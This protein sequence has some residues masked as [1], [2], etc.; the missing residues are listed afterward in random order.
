M[1]R[2][3]R[4]ERS[5]RAPPRHI[6]P[7]VRVARLCRRA[8]CRRRA[9][10]TRRGRPAEPRRCHGGTPATQAWRF[11]CSRVHGPDRR[12]EDNAVDARRG[13]ER[14]NCADRIGRRHAD[15]PSARVSAAVVEL[16]PVP[17]MRLLDAALG[18]TDLARRTRRQS[19]LN[20]E[21]ATGVG[22]GAP[23]A[24]ETRLAGVVVA[25]LKEAFDRDSRRLDLERE[26]I[27]A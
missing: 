7:G 12:L 22:A 18:L 9:S 19:P 23:G 2:G 16:M 11:D 14:G 15:Q 1:A 6:A 3:Y 10:A 4:L 13:S 8:R 17:W 5:R 26:Q 24:L 25:A 20:E 27:E 21:L